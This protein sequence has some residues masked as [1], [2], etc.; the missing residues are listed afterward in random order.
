MRL[1]IQ[2][3]ALVALYL[4][5]AA[6][7]TVPR[8]DAVALRTASESL[9]L[10]R[11]P[12]RPTEDRAAYFL[13]AAST[14]NAGFATPAAEFRARTIY[15]SAA[16]ELTNLLRTADGGRLW[17]RPL[18]VTAGGASYRLNFQPGARE[19]VWEPSYFTDF[20]LAS[21]V[22]RKHLRQSVI[23]DGFG[24]TLVGIKKTP[25]IIPGDPATFEPRGGFVA[26][27]TA[28]LDFRQRDVTLTLN[29]PAERKTVRLAGTERPLAA[30]FSAPYAVHP[31]QNELWAGLMAMIHVQEYLRGTGLYMIEPYDPDRIPVI[32]IHGL[33]ST[34]QMWTNTINEME[35]DPALRGRFQYWVFRYPTGNPVTYSAMRCREE[36]ARMQRLHPMPRGFIMIGHS[37][38]GLIS[39]M[40]AT[41]AGRAVWD[42][43]LGKQADR[44]FAKLP[45][46]DMVKRVLLFNSNPQARRIVFICT[47]H[48]GSELALGSIGTMAIKLIQLPTD[49]VAAMTKSAGDI[50]S[51]VGGKPQI[52]NSITSLSPKNPTL[53][54]MDK[55]PIRAPHHSIIGDR[56][57]GN[58]PH[59]SDG[60]VPYWSSHL[61]SAQSELIVPGPHGSFQLPQTIE[62]LR[63]ILRLHLGQPTAR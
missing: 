14:V 12:T 60:I 34:P 15:N 47:P 28:T 32:F 42:A 3:S 27:V 1:P 44:K 58:T 21:K 31:V 20:K 24:G 51:M 56:G 54:A 53:I 5:L 39:R 13:E 26:P 57:K 25:G 36:L 61:A 6:C 37:M 49:F 10:A 55:L 16:A 63:R 62:E 22:R 38:G 30:D 45:S 43:N 18:E 59:S 46:D 4:A 40:Q 19:G 17:N 48:R 52:P 11:S 33:V 23:E 7:S 8:R 35:A 29:D 9:K 41:D 50:L 2:T